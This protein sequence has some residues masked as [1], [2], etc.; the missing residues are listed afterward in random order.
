MSKLPSEIRL[1]IARQ[2]SQDVWKLD[3]LLEVIKVEV[4]AR[5]I[6]EGI[7]VSSQKTQIP[8]Q[9]H[10]NI[11]NSTASSLFTSSGRIQCIYSGKDHFSASC[12]K[13]CTVKEQKDI[14]LSSGHCFNFL[15][16]IHKSKE[17]NSPRA[18]RHCR[19][20]HHQSVCEVNLPLGNLSKAEKTINTAANTMNGKCTILLQTA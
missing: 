17:C 19:R 1:R 4:E 12:D 10:T 6:S 2:T 7:R 8:S 5:E 18:C 13:I 14:L 9:V 11:S 15:K 20:K 16:Q 3:D